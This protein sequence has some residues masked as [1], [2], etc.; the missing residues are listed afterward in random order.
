MPTDEEP[1][2][3]PLEKPTSKVMLGAAIAL[4]A[5]VVLY[6]AVG[7][8]GMN[9]DSS[10]TGRSHDMS[11]MGAAGM[12]FQTVEP[13]AFELRMAEPAAFVI[14][15][16]T[17]YEGEIAGTDAFLAFDSVATNTSKLPSLTT[18]I[19]V[20]CRRGNMSTTAAATLIA[21]GYTDVVELK[22]GMEAWRSSG[23]TVD[24]AGTT[25][26]SPSGT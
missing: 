26:S 2:G 16:H 7:M 8:P 15:V 10:G 21:L 9:H 1:V 24:E 13:A 12:G 18:P 6:L 19:L 22:G 11:S 23:R 4:V 20:Y 3:R 14:N 25:S 17:P 5:G